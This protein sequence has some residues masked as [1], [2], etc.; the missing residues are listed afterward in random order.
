MVR[1]HAVA[2]STEPLGAEVRPFSFECVDDI[3]RSV[4]T[5]SQTDNG[6]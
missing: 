5:A 6:R 1:I 4:E 3:A 2:D